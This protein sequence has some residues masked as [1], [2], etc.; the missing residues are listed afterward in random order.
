MNQAAP[1]AMR[2]RS[3]SGNRGLRTLQWLHRWS[4][5]VCTGFLL[6]LC[7]TGLPLIFSD[8]IDH[9]TDPPIIYERLPESTPRTNLDRISDIAHKMYPGQIISSVAPNADEPQ[10][11]VWMAPSFEA[12]AKDPDVIHFIRFDARTARVLE[13]SRSRPERGMTFL[14]FMLQLHV[15]FFAGFAG[16]MFLAGM[17]VLFV[18]SLVSGVILYSPFSRKLRFGA[19]RVDKSRRTRWLDLHNLLGIV[20]FTWMAVVGATGVINE[21]ASPLV[22]LWKNTDVKEIIDRNLGESAPAAGDLAGPQRIYD[23][24]SNKLPGMTLTS[25]YYPGHPSGSPYHF[26]AWTKGAS[27]LTARLTTPV[28]L[29]ARTGEIST[30]VQMPWYLRALEVS[31]PLHFGDYGGAPLKI[32]WALL[33]LVSIV[34][35][36]TG[37]YLW[38][39][40]GAANKVRPAGSASRTSSDIS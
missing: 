13:D 39:K 35:L 37:L 33:D 34:V 6:V 23:E 9:W 7:V 32:I 2:S 29:D 28:L 30:I 8:E 1:F 25:I 18:I 15:S 40:K 27:A 12:R 10:V 38:F 24:V 21:L 26:V 19:I 11:L 31:R 20:L 3:F 22:A 14:G 4:S 16:Q 17:G 36:V 5:L